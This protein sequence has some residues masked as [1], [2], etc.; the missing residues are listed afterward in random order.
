MDA[1]PSAE[2]RFVSALASGARESMRLPGNVFDWRVA[3]QLCRRH[4]IAA[5]CG[6]MIVGL[7]EPLRGEGS[8][9]AEYVTGELREN[10]SRN[11][12]LL[13]EL[14]E[15]NEELERAGVSALFFKGPW[16]A[17]EA[18]PALG[19]R[20]IGD[21]DLGISETEYHS[22]VD[23]LRTLGYQSESALPRTSRDALKRAHY[24]EQLRFSADGRWPVEL[25][26]R[27]VNL[28][29]PGPR[30]GWVDRTSREF[31]IGHSRLRV[32]GPEA[33]LVHLLIHANQHGFRT[34]RLL[35]DIRWQ[36]EKDV[37]KVDDSLL[38][39]SIERLR[40]R[41]C[42][43]FGLALAREVAGAKVPLGW[44]DALRPSS[45]RAR[46][47]R[48]LWSVKRVATLDPRGWGQ[49]LEA[50][51]FYLLEMGGPLDKLRYLRGIL[52]W[53]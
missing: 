38:L 10:T 2:A 37:G 17:H 4:Q 18:Y 34:L 53:V 41:T 29:P 16:L 44:M 21:I 28:G 19:T 27:M 6:Y 47:Y 14:R 49:R 30:E 13:A 23:M 9:F 25:H 12:K 24:R 52:G 3:R 31:S 48:R 7:Q 1:T 36:L 26:F 45:L 51:R 35:H 39:S 40:M 20:L 22:A 46:A 33:M 43:F 5:L 42:A 11:L 15:L 50:P 8:D 32:P